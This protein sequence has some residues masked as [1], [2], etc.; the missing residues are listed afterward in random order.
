MNLI[1]HHERVEVNGNLIGCCTV[2]GIN[3]G[4]RTCRNVIIYTIV[5]T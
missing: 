3:E 2:P 5:W 1:H 4:T